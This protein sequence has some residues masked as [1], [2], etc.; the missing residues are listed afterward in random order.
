MPLFQTEQ[1]NA[2]GHEVGRFIALQRHA[3]SG[4]QTGSKK[5]ATGLDLGIFGVAH[6]HARRLEALGRH[7]WDAPA[8]EQG[9]H[10][11]AQLHLLFANFREAV[12]LGLFHDLAQTR[13]GVGR[14]GGMVGM[15][16]AFI[17]L[18]DLQPLLEVAGIA[19]AGRAVDGRAG[20][21]AEHHHGAAGRT[22]PA[23]LRRT[24]QNIDTDI[25]HV[26]PHRTRGNAVQHK[27]TTD[28]V[29]RGRDRAQVIVGQYH[30]AGCFHVRCKNHVGLLG[31]N[32][33]HHFVNRRRHPG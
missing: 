26:H 6:D 13:Q 19:A 33:G 10:L 23:L 25:D 12:S 3:G 8:L 9:P 27:K 22:A 14:H 30:A 7:A 2:K 17:G 32:G 15:G 20:T 18:H 29:H 24:D 4:L 28:F 31:A 11:G 5:L 16:T 21:L 1:T